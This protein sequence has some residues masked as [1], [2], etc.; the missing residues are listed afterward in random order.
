MPNNRRQPN[1]ESPKPAAPFPPSGTT[2]AEAFTRYT[3]GKLLRVGSTGEAWRSIKAYLV[4][5]LHD[6]PRALPTPATS[7]PF[8]ACT[9]S[10]EA[11]FYEREGGGPWLHHRLRRGSFFLTTGGGPYE[12]RYESASSAPW[13]S[14][15]AFISLPLMERALAEVFGPAEAPQARLRDLSA[16]T[17]PFLLSMMDSLHGELLAKK[18][19]PLFVDGIAQAVAIHLARHYAQPGGEHPLSSAALPGYR[20]QQITDW[21]ARHLAEDIDLEQLA[22]MSG[23]SKFHFHRLFKAAIGMSPRRYHAQLRLN[24]ARRLLR[25]RAPAAKPG[26]EQKSILAVALAVGYSNPSHFARL[27]RRE[28]GLSPSE[29]RRSR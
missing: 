24:E 22:A 2:S 1:R 10:G 27:F 21:M 25:E 19:S 15:C 11:D 23:L 3:R 12:C 8:L 29:Y 9:L 28:T 14:I 6:Q 7:E 20:L 26:D 17:D 18:P 13:Q 5:H 16:F 4:D